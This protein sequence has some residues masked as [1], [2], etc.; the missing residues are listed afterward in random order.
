M[1]ADDLGIASALNDGVVVLAP[2]GVIGWANNAFARLIGRVLEDLIGSDGFGLVHP[3]EQARALDGMV[4]ASQFPD[5]TSVAPYRLLHGDGSWMS[6]ELKSGLIERDDG[7][8]VVLVVR[9]G[10]NRSNLNRAL[11]SIAN[12]E[13]LE[14]TAAVLGEAVIARWPHTGA[15]VS[16][17]DPDGS[18]HVVSTSLESR[19]AKAVE[20]DHVSRLPAGSS[21]AAVTVLEVGALSPDVGAAASAAGFECCASVT[22]A[23]PA[24]VPAELAVWF[25]QTLIAELEFVHAAAEFAELL[26]LALERRHRL[27]QLQYVAHHDPLTGLLNRAGFMLRFDAEADATRAIVGESLIVLYLDLD[28]LKRANDE[29]GHAAG[30]RVLVD[31]ARRLRTIAGPSALVGRLGGDEFVVATRCATSDVNDHSEQLAD[32]LVAALCFPV[33]PGLDGTGWIDVSV[34]ASVGLAVDDPLEPAMRTIERADAA[35]YRAKAAGKCRWS[36]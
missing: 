33:P 34:A 1:A 32:A 36:I 14:R 26:T 3:D 29:G 6:V 24:G 2:D 18:R 9:D 4:Y 15:S 8:H 5:R 7:T 27:W 13:T 22:I 31:V 21:A 17:E 12:G 11:Q 28:A 25:D 20:T 23:D 30:D 16:F 35:M 19:L 10:T